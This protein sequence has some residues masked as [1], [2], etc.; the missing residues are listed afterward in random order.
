M[1]DITCEEWVYWFDRNKW[2]PFQ[3]AKLIICGP[4]ICVGG[5]NLPDEE[6]CKSCKNINKVNYILE[7]FNLE[8]CIKNVNPEYIN[9]SGF[10]FWARQKETINIPVQMKDWYDE[11]PFQNDTEHKYI[12]QQAIE[13]A[14]LKYKDVTAKRRALLVYMLRQ[15]GYSNASIYYGT[16]ASKADAS[17]DSI[18]REVNNFYSEAKKILSEFQNIQK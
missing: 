11:Y 14:I 16:A 13:Q 18:R 5:D 15:A 6:P 3:G 2:T 8:I 4:R 9:P 12:T 17:P 10:I 1:Q 7:L